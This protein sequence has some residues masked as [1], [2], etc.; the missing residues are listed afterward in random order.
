MGRC[1]FR[2]QMDRPW[3]MLLDYVWDGKIPKSEMMK[4]TH[5]YGW[6]LVCGW[7]PPV[8]PLAVAAICLFGLS[9]IYKNPVVVFA[10]TLFCGSLDVPGADDARNGWLCAAIWLTVSVIS[11]APPVSAK[12]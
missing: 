7:L 1:G 12:T 3:L 10:N 4:L 5:R 9:S 6:K 2:Q 11:S 8:A